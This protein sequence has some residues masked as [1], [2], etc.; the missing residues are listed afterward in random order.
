MMLGVVE[1]GAGANG[2]RRG[3]EWG[4]GYLS[5]RRAVYWRHRGIP[6][7]SPPAASSFW[8]APASS[9]LIVAGDCRRLQLVLHG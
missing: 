3:L 1:G 2:G 5:C 7:S 6:L 4:R 8:P 9:S